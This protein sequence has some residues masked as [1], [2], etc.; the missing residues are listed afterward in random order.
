LSKNNYVGQDFKRADY[1]DVEFIG[2]LWMQG[3]RD[4]KNRTAAD[5]YEKNLESFIKKLRQDLKH[6]NFLL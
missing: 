2:V 6:H 5:E 3:E 1:E 4:G